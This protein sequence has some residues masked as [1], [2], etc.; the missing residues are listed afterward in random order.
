MEVSLLKT[1][2]PKPAPSNNLPPIHPILVRVREAHRPLLADGLH[3][4]VGGDV[5]LA[6]VGAEVAAGTVDD[7]LVVDGHAAAFD[8][9]K[10]HLVGRFGFDDEGMRIFAGAARVVAFGLVGAQ[11]GFVVGAGHQLEAA[12][13]QGGIAEGQREGGRPGILRFGPV[14]KVLVHGELCFGLV[15]AFG[16]ELLVIHGR[17]SFG[18]EL[19]GDVLADA[20]VREAR[21]QV[22]KVDFEGANAADQVN[23]ISAR[24]ITLRNQTNTT[25]P[26][27][28]AI[29][30]S[31]VISFAPASAPSIKG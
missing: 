1:Q 9:Q 6:P 30:C 18:V 15:G 14:A 22:Q 31:L 23:L 16:E 28:P 10:N 5:S 29:P 2:S 3:V 12:V 7:A 24:R 25:Q 27:C 21:P 17:L 19:I 11:L 8:R 26:P 4:A 13:F 20:G